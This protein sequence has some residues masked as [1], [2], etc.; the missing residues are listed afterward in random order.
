MSPQLAKY[1]AYRKW[2]A[3]MAQSIGVAPD[4]DHPL[5]RSLGPL[6]PVD[7]PPWLVAGVRVRLT[8]GASDDDGVT[9]LETSPELCLVQGYWSPLKWAIETEI[10]VRSWEVVP[11]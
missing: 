5:L 10:I 1:A 2:M 7:V 9:V 6:V 4:P 11:T 8:E 3:D